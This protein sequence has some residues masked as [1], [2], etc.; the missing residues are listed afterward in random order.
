MIPIKDPIDNKMPKII[1]IKIKKDLIKPN[2]A[3]G[4]KYLMKNEYS[5]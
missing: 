5:D 4:E 3:A 1:K 2:Q